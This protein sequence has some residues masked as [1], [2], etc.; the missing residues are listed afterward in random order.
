M[1]FGKYCAFH[2]EAVALNC[3]QSVSSVGIANGCS[4]DGG[5]AA[6][7]KADGSWS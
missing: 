6:R 2:P 4:L 7:V 3:L 1:K 5:G